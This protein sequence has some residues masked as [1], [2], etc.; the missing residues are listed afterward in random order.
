MK[1]TTS[2]SQTLTSVSFYRLI[3]AIALLM[4]PFYGCKHDD[5]V[6]SPTETVNTQQPQ[7][8]YITVE[9]AKAYFDEQVAILKKRRLKLRVVSQMRTLKL[10][11][12]G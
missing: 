5:L 10:H 3:G 1:Q 12:M 11:L 2:F 6:I 9:K 4:L 8:S 7:K